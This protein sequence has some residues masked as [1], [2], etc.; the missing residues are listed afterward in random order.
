MNKSVE[1]LTE[2]AEHNIWFISEG[3]AGLIDF[4]KTADHSLYTTLYFPELDTQTTKGA[5]FIYP[6]NEQNIFISSNDGL[7]HLNYKE[8]SQAH[9]PLKVLLST[10][11]TINGDRDSLI[12]G[13][14]HENLPPKEVHM[15]Y[16]WNSFH[17]EYSSTLYGQKSNVEF[18]YKLQ[19]FDKEWSAW[20]LKTE[21]DYTNLPYGTYMFSVRGRNNLGNASVPVNYTFTVDPA[22]Y[23]TIWAYLVY[24]IIA[25]FLVNMIVNWQKKRFVLH[26]QKHEEEQA[27]LTYLH[28]LEMDRNEKEIITLQKENLEAELQFKNK[29]LATVTMNLVERGGILLNIKQAL[30]TMMKKTSIPDPEHEFRSIFRILDDIE[31]KGDDWNQFAIYFDQVHNNFLSTLKNKYT[32]LSSTDLKLCAYLRLNLSSK[33]IAQLM[34]IS[35]KGVEISRYRI[36]KKLELTTEVNLYDFLIRTTQNPSSDH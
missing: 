31:K 28:S 19:G 23:E 8:Y 12:F 13:G 36:R 26:Q 4:N 32:S 11:K 6:Y 14:Y 10:V 33:E 30:L 2:D 18:S 34:N 5:D 16:Q 15:A 29:E 9:S 27:R 22:W 7:F 3:R 17:F 20:S 25:A 21:K 35:L 1:Y 24:F